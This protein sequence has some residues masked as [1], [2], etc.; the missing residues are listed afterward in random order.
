MT[1]FRFSRAVGAILSLSLAMSAPGS[2]AW[3]QVASSA[4]A[5]SAAGIKGPVL[6]L[7]PTAVHIS[8]P[9]LT[10][11]APSLAAPILAPAPRSTR[12]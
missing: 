7:T 1:N 4:R 6:S 3:G 10:L 5:G 8:A 9:A 12:R 11:S 2:Q